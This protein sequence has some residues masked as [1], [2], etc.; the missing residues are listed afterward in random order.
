MKKLAWKSKFKIIQK[1]AFDLFGIMPVLSFALIVLSMLQ[2]IVAVYKVYALA[3]LIDC[4]G[5]VFMHNEP[6][7]R[8]LLYAGKLLLCYILTQLC[9]LMQYKINNIDAAHKMEKFHHR[10]SK[11][12]TEISLEAVNA[13]EIQ[14][15]FWRAKDAIYQDRISS[16]FFTAFSIVPILFQVIGTMLVLAKYHIALVLIAFLSVFPAAATLFV[17]G[18]KEYALNKEQT[19]NRRRVE[20]LWSELTDRISIREGRIFGFTDY[21][22]QK[23]MGAHQENFKA[24]RQMALR[25]YWGNF[26]ANCIK[27][28]LYAVAI[29]LS[30]FLVVLGKISIGSFSSCISIFSS[31]QDL[32]QRLFSYISDMNSACNYACDYYDFFRIGR[33]DGNQN[34]MPKELEVL[35]FR[36]VSYSYPGM[37]N[38]AVDHVSFKIKKGQLVVIVGENGSG[39]TTL[40]K[41]LL[42]LYRPGEG[43]IYYN[44]KDIFSYR[45]EEY[46][47]KFSM[48]IQ[49][50]SKYALTLRE[51]IAFSSLKDKNDENRISMAVRENELLGVVDKMDKGIDTNLGIEFG[52][53]D[54]SGGE[55]Q[56]VA[57]ARAFFRDAQLLVLDEPTSAIDPLKEYALLNRFI[58]ISKEK[59]SIIISHRVGICRKAD[60]IL[61]MDDGKLAEIGKHDDLLA[62]GAKYCELWNAQAKWY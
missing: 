6:D 43:Q 29:A 34:G 18:N 22:K 7:N 21:I 20:Y 17:L 33:E 56:K 44:D 55:W 42:G 15:M 14:N 62:A 32:A 35:E 4:A 3:S 37:K 16:V 38:K 8:L 58:K 54:L 49:N 24:T 45:K 51:N 23:Y 53:V 61:V 27:Y 19:E 48:A 26:F 1:S 60:V 5:E 36:N 28:L 39:K 47:K 9:S 25:I 11:Q 30:I 13:S 10:L 57:L 40:S 46:R 41:L 12:L 50:F 31:M 52:D 59:T 2:A